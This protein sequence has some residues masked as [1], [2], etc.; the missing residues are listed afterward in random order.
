[1]RTLGWVAAVTALAMVP[2]LALMYGAGM[3]LFFEGGVAVGPFTLF[4]LDPTLPG[5]WFPAHDV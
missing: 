3:I 4:Y 2:T 5:V 1:M